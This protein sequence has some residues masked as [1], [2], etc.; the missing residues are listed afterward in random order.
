MKIVIISRCS[1]VEWIVVQEVIKNFKEVSIIQP[2]NSAREGYLGNLQNWIA[3]PGEK[4]INKVQKVILNRKLKKSF[5]NDVNPEI[6]QIPSDQI[7]EQQGEKLISSFS[8]D[9][10]IT[11]YAPILKEVI[12]N[13]PRLASINIHYGISPHYRGNHTLFWTLVKKDFQY[14]GGTIH[15]LSKG[16]DTGNILARVYPT[17]KP[18]DG[19][20]DLISK[21]AQ[22]LAKA[23]VVVLKKIE[24]SESAPPGRI[25]IKKG[26]N[27]KSAERTFLISMKFFLSRKMRVHRNES[28]SEKLEFFI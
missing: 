10:L 15:Y 5:Y 16:V 1:P 22:L 8:P 26:R 2:T 6:I 21:T 3:K 14:I 9:V 24:K 18:A 17:L 28:V 12:F 23:L 4:I 20:L 19:E 27:F 13:I 25:Q 11:C 7:N